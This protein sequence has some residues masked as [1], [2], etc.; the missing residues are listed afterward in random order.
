IQSPQTQPQ[1]QQAQFQQPQ[2]QPLPAQPSPQ[3]QP[4]QPGTG[5][6]QPVLD[7]PASGTAG[8][9]N[10]G[11]GPDNPPSDQGGSSE[12]APFGGFANPTPTESLVNQAKMNDQRRIVRADQSEGS[13]FE[14]GEREGPYEFVTTKK[15]PFARYVTPDLTGH[16]FTEVSPFY[17]RQGPRF[18]IID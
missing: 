5:A 2:I 13:G 17:V 16:V 1:V 8:G 4:E 11:S 3:T 9:G 12:P 18:A 7:G 15:S 10:A 14:F 6:N